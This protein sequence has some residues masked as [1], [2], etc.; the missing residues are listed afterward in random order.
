MTR[1]SPNSAPRLVALA[2]ALVVLEA[3]GG[4]AMLAAI[5]LA[6]VGLPLPA[7]AA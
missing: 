1:A 6:T 2:P 3:T 5:T 7:G 4:F